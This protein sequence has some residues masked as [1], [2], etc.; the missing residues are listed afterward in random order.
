MSQIERI[1]KT[2]IS[3]CESLCHLRITPRSLIVSEKSPNVN[4]L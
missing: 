3:I 1:R 4:P 2:E